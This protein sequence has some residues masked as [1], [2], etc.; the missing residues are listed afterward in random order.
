M[1]PPFIVRARFHD[2]EGLQEGANVR[3]AGVSMGVV[4]KIRH[5]SEEC[6]VELEMHIERQRDFALPR[7]AKARL[8]S[9]RL[10]GPTNRE[11]RLDRSLRTPDRELRQTGNPEGHRRSCLQAKRQ[12][13]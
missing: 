8:G 10:L 12:L 9:E 3:V 4:R 1:H 6:P 5:Q 2:V 13:L 7:S 11:H